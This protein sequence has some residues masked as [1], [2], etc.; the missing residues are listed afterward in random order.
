MEINNNDKNLTSAGVHLKQEFNSYIKW[1]SLPVFLRGQPEPVLQKMGIDDPEVFEL[2]KTRTQT[3]FAKKYGIRD[4]GTLSDWN[5]IIQKEGLME[6]IYEWARQLTP[7]VV[8]AL[9]KNV[10]KNGR[11][12]EVR[13]WFELIENN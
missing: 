13:A 1:R 2:L 9:Y 7:N 5:K 3:E 8:L 11:A 12:H 4:L 6:N 10:A